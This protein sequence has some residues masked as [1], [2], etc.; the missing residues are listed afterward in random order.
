MSITRSNR[1]IWLT[2]AMY[3]MCM[4]AVDAYAQEASSPVVQSAWSRKVHGSAGIFDLP[5]SFSTTDPATTEPRRGPLVTVVV[6]FDKPVSSA[7]VA[8][9]GGRA[10]LVGAT[11]SGKD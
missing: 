9:V 2:V 4:F 8:V 5:L 10:L 3:L 6:R 7:D 1:P 11:F